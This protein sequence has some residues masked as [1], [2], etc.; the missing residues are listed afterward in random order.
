MSH[1]RHDGVG[2]P[3]GD[4]L[5][6]ARDTALRRRC[7]PTGRRTDPVAAM[8]RSTEEKTLKRKMIMK[9]IKVPEKNIVLSQPITCHGGLAICQR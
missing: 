4:G 6:G 8:I 1:L 3:R 5:Y 7:D 9:K 2:D